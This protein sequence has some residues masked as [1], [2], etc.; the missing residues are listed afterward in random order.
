MSSVSVATASR[1]PH[2]KEAGAT[3]PRS[4]LTGS[5][6]L[7]VALAMLSGADSAWAS[8]WTFHHSGSL[9]SAFLYHPDAQP[10][11]LAA[12]YFDFAGREDITFGYSDAVSG[13]VSGVLQ[14][15]PHDS[16]DNRARFNDLYVSFYT[17]HLDLRLGFQLFS[18]KTVQS[19]SAAD[20]LNQYDYGLDF[21]NPSKMGDPAV[22]LSWSFHL[23]IDQTLTIF[24]L[25]HFQRALLPR[26]GT[27]NYL[28]PGNDAVAYSPDRVEY[29]SPRGEWRQQV[30]LSYD[31]TL[32][33]FADARA[34]YFNGYRR[35]PLLIPE[36]TPGGAVVVHER[37]ALADV[38]GGTMQKDL[39]S[40]LLS[41]EAVHYGYRGQVS[42]PSGRPISG[43]WQYAA[44]LERNFSSL[45]EGNG[46]ANV[47]FELIGDEFA[48]RKED[49]FE[50]GHLFRSSAYLGVR[51]VFNDSA[52]RVLQLYGIFDYRE[53]DIYV[54][55]TYTQTLFQLLSIQLFAS[56]YLVAKSNMAENLKHAN[57]IGASAA[58]TW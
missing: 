13:R 7:L 56:G 10:P 5:A 12:S 14:Y 42:S 40:A 51:Y 32:D 20:L 57:K 31:S 41:L 37:Y 2:A 23:G 48:G 36:L 15:D 4:A 52:R 45:F 3:Q 6:V 29:D 18:W 35:F 50:A 11:D 22:R 24:E 43:Y 53:G 26:K 38:F 39:G 44:G 8:E 47:A 54:N 9:G 21:L 58:L 46:E 25:P 55:A 34:F 49:D 1:R 16:D 30:A 33:G 27:N 19:L 28:F 17:D